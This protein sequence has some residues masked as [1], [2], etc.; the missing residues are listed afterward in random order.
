MLKWR[1]QDVGSH[2]FNAGLLKMAQK[3]TRPS[4]II[5]LKWT[6]QLPVGSP[7][8]GSLSYSE[9]T[10]ISADQRDWGHFTCRFFFYRNDSS[11]WI[12]LHKIF[13]LSQRIIY[14]VFRSK[15]MCHI[16]SKQ[17]CLKS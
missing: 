16:N 17:Y 5:K 13:F 14:G 1:K 2:T 4:R 7:Q 11:F 9:Q 12:S 10:R 15:K 6:E 8:T 3:L